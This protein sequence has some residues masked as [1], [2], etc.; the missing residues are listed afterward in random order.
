[1][2]AFFFFTQLA[3]TFVGYEGVSSRVVNV[4]TEKESCPWQLEELKADF[5]SLVA[6]TSWSLHCCHRLM[7]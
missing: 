4:I 2:A 6:S 5:H 7:N 3:L 1:M